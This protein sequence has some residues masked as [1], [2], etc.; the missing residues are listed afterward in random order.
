MAFLADKNR[1][2]RGEGLRARKAQGRYSGSRSDSSSDKRF[3]FSD[4]F[5]SLF[6]GQ[7]FLNL[8]N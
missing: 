4:E 5:R 6:L 3:Y 7:R 1:F 8:L 2:T